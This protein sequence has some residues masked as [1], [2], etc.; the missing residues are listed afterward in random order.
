M[1]ARKY[2]IIVVILLCSAAAVSAY[3]LKVD[4]FLWSVNSINGHAYGLAAFL[5]GNIVLVILLLIRLKLGTILSMFWGVAQIALIGGDIA[6]ALG[7][8]GMGF[9]SSDAFDYLIKGKGNITGLA[10]DALIVLYALISV[11]SL[12]AY[13]RIR[14]EARTSLPTEGDVKAPEAPEEAE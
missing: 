9:T 13:L 2:R 7:L 6:A 5:A 1:D 3:I 11:F 4:D 10:T 14:K 12:L 8:S